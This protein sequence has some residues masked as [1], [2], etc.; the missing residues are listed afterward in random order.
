MPS[1]TSH[2]LQPL[3][4]SVYSSYKSALEKEIHEVARCK[5]VLD[6]FDVAQCIHMAYS[7][8][9]T[10]GNIIR[11][12]EKTGL[13]DSRQLFASVEPFITLFK[14]PEKIAGSSR[15]SLGDL[16]N[17]F[18]RKGRRQLGS[19]DVEENVTVRINTETDAHLT[20]N[21]VLDALKVRDD[22]RQT[23]SKGLSNS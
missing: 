17:S 18:S 6:A 19:A 3:D 12:F 4:V 5:L 2:F 21:S 13:W 14:A 7:K 20:S 10:S 1:H 16:V 11:G 23:R 8:S 15:V 9:M 22:R